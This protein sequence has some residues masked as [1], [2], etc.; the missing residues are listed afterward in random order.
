MYLIDY[1]AIH[2]LRRHVSPAPLTAAGRAPAQQPI[3]GWK[4]IHIVCRNIIR[5]LELLLNFSNFNSSGSFIVHQRLT[6]REAKEEEHD[7]ACVKQE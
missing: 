1:P 5:E 2:F 4:L 6:K 7:W 3:W